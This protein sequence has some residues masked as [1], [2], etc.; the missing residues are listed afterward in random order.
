MH[1]VWAERGSVRPDI[2][3]LCLA[4]GAHYIEIELALGFRQCFP[5]LAKVDIR[6][7]YAFLCILS[8]GSSNP[9]D[10]S[11]YM[12][13]S[14]FVLWILWFNRPKRQ[15]FIVWLLCFALAVMLGYVIQTGL[16]KLQAEAVE[17]AADWV[18]D[19]EPDPFKARTAIGDRGR[20]KL[21]S[22]VLMKVYSDK[23]LDHP[24]L[25]K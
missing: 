6:L 22:R 19:W 23:P 17:W 25:L 7:P 18:T 3:D 11:Y 2:E 13:V 21:S 8:A 16:V 10:Q 1:I 12:G 15:P 20:L 4:V 24:L 9:D 5:G 14:A